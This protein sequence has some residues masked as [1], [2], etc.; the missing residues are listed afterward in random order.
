MESIA[1]GG[2]AATSTDWALFRRQMPVARHWA[3]FDHAAVAP[4]SGPAQDAMLR[5][6]QDAAD[7]GSVH[8]PDW[9]RQIEHL[10]TSAAQLIG[11]L[12]EEI[13]LVANTTAGI[14]LRRR[15]LSLEARR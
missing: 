1:I 6:T 3:Y 10:R 12:P 13:A 4:L 9:T 7:H 2:A 11:A 15:R 5:W 14:K 8:Y